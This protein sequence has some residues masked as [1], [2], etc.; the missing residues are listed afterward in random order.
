MKDNK[1]S[2]VCGF[3][4]NDWHLTTMLLPY[5]NKTVNENEKV[6]TI[7][8]VG[9]KDKVE[10]LL[11]KMNLKPETQNKILEINWSG[12]KTC[13]YSKIKE[14][15]KQL[16]NDVQAINIITT[17]TQDYINK[18]NINIQKLLNEITGKKVTIIDCYDATLYK[19]IDNILDEHEFVL[20]ASGIKKIE[21]VF[22]NYNRN[23]K[24]G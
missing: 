18:A 12:N 1:I 17:G 10:E 20:N 4:V 11:S 8:E 3:Y 7:L 21:E 24:I 9:I 16:A 23:V 19:E 22:P 6:L 5:V 15:I 13:N 2:K 14:Q